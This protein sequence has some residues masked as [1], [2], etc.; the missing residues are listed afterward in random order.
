MA[1]IVTI[2]LCLKNSGR[3]VKYALD[4]ISNQDYPHESL[5]LV[6]VD[7]NEC[8]STLSYLDSFV[9]DTDIKTTIFQVKNK[10]LGA[11]RQIV[12]DNA[13]GDYILWVD[14]DYVLN[15]DFVTHQVKFMEQNPAIGAARAKELLSNSNLF[16]LLDSYIRRLSSDDITEVSLGDYLI[17]R[18]NAIAQ[19][20]GFDTKIRGAGEDLD[21]SY[22]IASSGWLLS[23]NESAVFEKKNPPQTWSAL[24]RKL[25]WYGYGR[26]FFFGKV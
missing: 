2:G 20:G 18:L 11:S 9:R 22:R 5:K 19:I 3:T 14:D 12:V 10:G 23:G 7:E 8:G 25:F 6:I 24:W 1:A 16:T 21:I 4:S 17:F 13:I 26:P 15:K